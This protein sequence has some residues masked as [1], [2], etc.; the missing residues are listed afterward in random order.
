MREYPKNTKRWPFSNQYSIYYIGYRY[1]IYGGKKVQK[2][3]TLSGL[4]KLIQQAF[5]KEEKN[6]KLD[7]SLRN[8]ENLDIICYI[9]NG[10][11]FFVPRS[12]YS[13]DSEHG[14]VWL[15]DIPE[16]FSIEGS[17]FNQSDLSVPVKKNNRNSYKKKQRKKFNNSKEPLIQLGSETKEKAEEEL[18]Y[19][20]ETP[21]KTDLKPISGP[22]VESI[23]DARER[24]IAAVV[25]RR[26]QPEFRKALIEAYDSSCAITG[27]NAVEALEAAHISPYR[28]PDTNRPSNGL[29][30]RA[31]L[32]TLFDLGLIAVDTKT[33]TVVLAESLIDTTYAEINGQLLRLPAKEAFR[34]NLRALDKHKSE[35]KVG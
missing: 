34:P 6:P 22:E 18:T 16:H 20:E 30:L 4:I 35:S 3:L 28:G 10:Q 26:G 33:M 25:R 12:I 5:I 1:S 13:R 15:D 7:S 9:R 31:D 29:L 11:E 14:F 19:P 8:I 32:H 17:I 21:I 23:I 2:S 24:V 27:C